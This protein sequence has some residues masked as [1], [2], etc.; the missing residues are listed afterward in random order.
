L[1]NTLLYIL[2]YL[3]S[4]QQSVLV[5]HV[6]CFVITDFFYE[7]HFTERQKINIIGAAAIVSVYLLDA[8]E[9]I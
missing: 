5:P 2:V 8:Q 9:T 4:V 6:K 3:L 7:T 1:T